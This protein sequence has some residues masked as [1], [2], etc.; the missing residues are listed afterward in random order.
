MSDQT[1]TT[2]YVVRHGQSEANVADKHGLDTK[3]SSKGKEQAKEAARKFKDLTFDAIFSSPLVRAKE[4]A[5]IIA[6]E[7]KLEVLTHDALR[8]R[9]EG[10]LDGRK[11]SEVKKE[12]AKMYEMRRELPYEEWKT[13]NLVEGY[14]ADESLMSRF[15]TALREIAIAYPGKTILVASHVGIMK[16]FL[17]HLGMGTHKTLPGQAFKNTGFIKLRTD[18]VDF[19]VD[20]L[21]GVDIEKS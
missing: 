15:I 8:E 11:G 17:I 13:K 18:G 14:E 21:N 1:Y 3:L 10:I 9:H 2:I 20:E 4:T 19:F 5:E 6:E 7:H 12:F 16:T